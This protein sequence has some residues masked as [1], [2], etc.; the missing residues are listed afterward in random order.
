MQHM[1]AC[2][3]IAGQRRMRCIKTWCDSRVIT[4]S[5]GANCPS[6]RRH[7]AYTRKTEMRHAVPSDA[8]NEGRAVSIVMFSRGHTPATLAP[9]RRH[10]GPRRADGRRTKSGTQMSFSAMCT[11]YNNT[12]RIQVSGWYPADQPRSVCRSH[13]SLTGNSPSATSRCKL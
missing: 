2:M 10:P 9:P 1:S 12:Q 7:E 8:Q 6:Q 11:P 5:L 13:E 3:R 4:P